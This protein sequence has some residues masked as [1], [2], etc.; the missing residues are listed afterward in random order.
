MFSSDESKLTL[1]LHTKRR[2]CRPVL[3]A[4]IQSSINVGTIQQEDKGFAKEYKL[5]GRYHN[6]IET[7]RQS[8]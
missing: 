7:R 4:K 2:S 8:I 6:F 3:K 5:L 1:Q